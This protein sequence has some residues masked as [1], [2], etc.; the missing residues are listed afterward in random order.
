M[1]ARLQYT[2][3]PSLCS[4][5]VE[6]RDSGRIFHPITLL[7][8]LYLMV[9]LQGVR[10]THDVSCPGSNAP[11]RD[12]S[13][14]DVLS[15]TY[16]HVPMN[17]ANQR[18]VIFCFSG[19]FAV[20]G[21]VDDLLRSTRAERYRDVLALELPQGEA[22]VFLFGAVVFW[23]VSEHDR[24]SL[25]E[26]LKSHVDELRMQTEEESY[27]FELNS[28]AEKFSGDTVYFTSHDR[29]HRL[30]V[31]HALAQSVQLN[32]F[33]HR[34]LSTIQETSEIPHS[35]AAQGGIQL[36]RRQTAMMRGNLFL[37]KSDI[38]L[39]YDLLDTPEFFWEYPE[40]ETTYAMAA[41]YLEIKPRV[42]VLAKKL[43]T[44]HELFEMLADE[45]RHKHSARL[46]WIIIWLIAIEILFFLV[47]DIAGFI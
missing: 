6:H 14:P 12:A 30:A 5:H 11:K 4:I 3:Y 18:V 29:M 40:L 8:V 36:S 31:A 38:I 47:H 20:P 32:Q 22:N 21:M 44:I 33:E 15:C 16:R 41:R 1:Q 23:G 37:T 9:L 46:E 10:Y 25:I 45:Q 26:K 42:D 39:N 13:D 27:G 28:G 24:R 35:L 2:R 7:S 43:E 19:R 34:A 17:F